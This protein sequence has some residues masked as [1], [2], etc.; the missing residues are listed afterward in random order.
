MKPGKPTKGMTQEDFDE[1]VEEGGRFSW[2]EEED[3]VIYIQ[4]FK[5]L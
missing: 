2:S 4:E 5:T 1:A 3:R